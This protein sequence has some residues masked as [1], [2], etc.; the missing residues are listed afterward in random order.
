MIISTV[1]DNS[2]RAKQAI[3]LLWA[4]AFLLAFFTLLNL[5]VPADAED[6]LLAV[7][8]GIV[9]LVLLGLSIITAVYFIRWFRR[10]YANLKRAGRRIQHDD[11]WAAGAWFVPFLNLFRPY[12]IMKEV[13]NGTFQ[14]AYAQQP[15]HPLLRWWWIIFVLTSTLGRVANSSSRHAETA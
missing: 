7:V 4:T 12:S 3:M 6:D 10:A 11:G 5:L 8:Q 14:L 1:L 15:S 2:D 13:W 9:A